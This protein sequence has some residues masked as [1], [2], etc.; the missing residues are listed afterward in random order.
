MRKVLAVSFSF[1]A[2][3]AISIALPAT[4]SAGKGKKKGKGGAVT[5]C[6]FGCK[7]KSIQKAA[8]KVGKNGKIKVKPGKY[9]EAVILKGKKYNGQTIMGTKKNAKKTVLNGKNAR[10]PGGIAQNGIEGIDVKKVTIKNLTVKNYA[11]NGVFFRDS[12]ARD[13]DKKLKCRDYLFKNII[14]ANNR[15]YGLF[16]FGC[17]GGRMTKS[18][19]YGHGDSA[20]YVGATPPQNNPKTTKLDHNVA[21]KNIQ[22][23]SGTNSRYNDIYKNV[24]YNNGIGLTPNTLDSEPYEPSEDNVIRK[25][26]IFWNNFNY[27]LPDSPVET[28]SNGLGQ[29][30]DTTINFP[31]GI[32]IVNFGVT[33]WEIKNNEIFGHEKWGVANFSDGG[34]TNE[35]DDAVANDNMITNNKMGRD[36]QDPNAF[37]F[38]NDGSG[39]GNCF[40]GNSS[41][42]FD[43]SSSTP[44]PDLYPGCPAPASTGTGTSTGDAEQF[45][46]VVDYVLSDPPA[47]Q[48]CGWPGLTHPKYKKYKPFMVTPGPDCP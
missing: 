1:L 11:T 15:S 12:D 19:G 34:L 23:Y 9:K 30:G 37:D 48:Q 21:Y 4:A 45:A 3:A 29:I 40:S 46:K 44:T 17:V 16:A 18:V 35:G 2:I 41:S 39:K 20:F 14:V 27:Y 42:T 47:T 22:A 36:G 25:N 43:T 33:G 6:K 32:G 31:I 38:F 8:D 26:E 7:Y 28:I 5:V 10:G 24:F 13:G